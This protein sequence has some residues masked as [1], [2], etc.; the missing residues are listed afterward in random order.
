MK[1]LERNREKSNRQAVMRGRLCS[2]L[3]SC[4]CALT[5][6]TI[7]NT[8]KPATKQASVSDNEYFQF[9]SPGIDIVWV[10]VVLHVAVQICSHHRH[11]PHGGDIATTSVTLSRNLI[12]SLKWQ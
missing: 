1:L 7:A 5:D 11:Q 3:C 9:T 4:S 10:L 2:W 12:V 6:P 8:N